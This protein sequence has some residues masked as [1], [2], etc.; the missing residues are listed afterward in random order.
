M[1]EGWNATSVTFFTFLGFT[2][3]PELQGLLF[4]LL[5]TIYFM[6]LSWN[7]GLI[8]LIRT[9]SHLHTPMYFF[10]GHLSFID[11]CYSSSVV[12]KTLSDFF[13]EPK[14]ISFVG[15]ATQFFVF[16]GMGLTECCLLA[17]MA[18]DRYAAICTPLRY[19]ATVTRTL[20]LQMVAG[21]YVAGFSSS[22]IQTTSIFH[23]R[24]CGPNIIDH[25]FCDLPPVLALSCSDTFGSQVVS[26]LVV[27]TVGGM[28]FLILLISYGAIGAAILKVRSAEGRCRAFHTCASHLMVVSLLYGPALFMYLCPSSSYSRGQD[29]VVALFYS[30]MT[31][32]LNPLIYSLRNKEIRGALHKMAERKRDLS[33]N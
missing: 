29:K 28:S 14:T 31:P 4:A 11:V 15:C 26:F 16:V 13:K 33:W 18:Y 19:Q 3:L 9:D 2:V 6:T 7:L 22:L 5:L 12:P 27:V 25:F 21:A 8:T 10:L 24:F 20:C 30:V 23:L 32:M 1:N 17:A